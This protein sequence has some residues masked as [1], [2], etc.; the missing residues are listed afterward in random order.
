[1]NFKSK[2]ICLLLVF[3]L[4]L[5]VGAVSADEMTAQSIIEESKEYS[6]VSTEIATDE[7]LSASN[8]AENLA[9]PDDGTFKALQ[10]KINNTSSGDIKLE[11]NYTY[12]DDFDQSGI[13]ISKPLTIDGAGYTIDAM[14]KGRIFNITS[15]NV[16]LKNINFKNAN[17]NDD[18]GQGGAIF[19]NGNFGILEN[20]IFENCS[21]VDGGG[22]IY[23]DGNSNGII[24]GCNFTDCSSQYG[25]AILSTGTQECS[26]VEC[27]FINCSSYSGGAI[28]WTAN[29]YGS[30]VGCNFTDCHS[31]GGGAIC[32]SE[33]NGDYI[34]DC[35]FMDCVATS[36]ES[37]GGGAICWGG[38][39]GGYVSNSTF[40]NCSATGNY[41]YGG[42]I[43]WENGNGAVDNCS[44]VG[45]SATYDGGAIYLCYSSD[46]SVVGCNFTDCS[47]R[48]NGGAIS[49]ENG[50]GAVYGGTI[51]SYSASSNNAVNNCIFTGNSAVNGSAI[52]SVNP[53]GTFTIKNSVLLN[54]RANSDQVTLTRNNNNN[55]TIVFTGKDNLLNAIYTEDNIDFDNVSY[56][57]VN[58]IM[59]TDSRSFSKSNK[60]EG[61]NISITI[62]NNILIDNYSI[63]KSIIGS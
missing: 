20:C 12:G 11:N 54:N 47:A 59:N 19:W 31:E 29:N 38:N 61:Q 30:V 45:C 62:N 60:E 28:F 48:L 51:G 21:A 43:K 44:F 23:Y 2:I 4:F 35:N 7:I 10:N 15:S 33:N 24:L 52:Y 22:A 36:D 5:S 56:W 46:N 49:W 8:D 9:S 58:G 1:M 18:F 17:Y 34:S 50:N 53:D 37:G 6:S 39:A 14:G 26:V 42:A 13:I 57:G 40:V 41:G 32:W 55:V 63:N 3:V 25:G 27:N 16:T